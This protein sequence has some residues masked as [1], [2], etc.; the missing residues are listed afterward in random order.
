MHLP[1]FS[2]YQCKGT[3]TFIYVQ[4]WRFFLDFT[5]LLS[6]FAANADLPFKAIVCLNGMQYGSG[7]ATGKRQ[8]KNEGG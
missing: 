1:S 8:A 7:V 6:C 3:V 2:W 5:S 4:Q